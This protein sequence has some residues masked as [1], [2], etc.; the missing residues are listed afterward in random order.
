MDRWRGPLGRAVAGHIYDANI[1]LH[2]S[3]I[4]SQFPT[5]GAFPH[6][7]VGDDS[8]D[9]GVALRQN[10]L[11]VIAVGGL[12][13]FESPLFE[14]LHHYHSDDGFIFRDEQNGSVAHKFAL[15]YVVNTGLARLPE[16]MLYL[17]Y[18]PRKMSAVDD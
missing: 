9:V 15:C 6:P 13:D 8:S 7:D 4:T 16:A 18:G 2:P 5:V 1:R 10:H 12:Q 14:A 17:C 11:S 3:Y